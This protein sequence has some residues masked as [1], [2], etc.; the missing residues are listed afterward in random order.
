MVLS[1]MY[2]RNKEWYAVKEINKYN[3]LQH[4]TG[5]DMIF[6]EL[7]ALQKLR[8]PF[9][10]RLNAAFHDAYVRLFFSSPAL[11]PPP[12]STPSSS[13][14]A[15]TQGRRVPRPRPQD[16]RRPPLLPAQEDHFFRAGRGVLRGLPRRRP[17][18]H[19]LD[20][21]AAP[22][23]QA[24]E[25]LAGLEGVSPPRRW[26]PSPHPTQQPRVSTLLLT[27]FLGRP[28]PPCR[29]KISA[30]RTCSRPTAR[31]PC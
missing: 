6:G 10:V 3:L 16:R 24:G 11:P 28:P 13:S 22:G 18:A 20:E 8:H 30:W 7:C 21:G 1:G 26:P 4:K 17:R 12:S 9:I 29:I 2:M 27:A 23:H 14:S 25:H 19:P 31:T 5:L 15:C